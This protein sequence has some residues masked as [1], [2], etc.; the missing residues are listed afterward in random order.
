MKPPNFFEDFIK[1]NN[2]F[3]VIAVRY[4]NIFPHLNDIDM[5][6]LAEVSFQH[7]SDCIDVLTTLSDQITRS[8]KF[9]GDFDSI[10]LLC[11]YIDGMYIQDIIPPEPEVLFQHLGYDQDW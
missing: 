2:Y 6:S 7:V 10:V 1:N 4:I 11:V 3:L 8:M 9:D 5:N